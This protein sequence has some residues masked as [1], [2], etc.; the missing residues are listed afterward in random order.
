MCACKESLT[1]FS[2]TIRTASRV[3]GLTEHAWLPRSFIQRGEVVLF[4]SLSL[5]VTFMHRT[6]CLAN[7][8]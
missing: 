7:A 1:C 4:L 5:K 8:E 6:L 2:T 3:V